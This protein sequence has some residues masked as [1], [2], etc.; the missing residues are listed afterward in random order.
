VDT[1]NDAFDLGGSDV[2]WGFSVGSSLKFGKNDVGRLQATYGEGIE[3][4]LN[5]APIDVGI[6]RTDFSNPR[7]P[8][9]G[10][11]IPV[12]GMSAFLDHNW[13]K[14]FTSAIGY[15]LVN[16][17]NSD[18]QVPSAFHR[19]QYAVANLLFNPVQNVMV[20]GEFQWGRRENNG[21]G[22]ASNDYRVQFSFRFNFSKGFTF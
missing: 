17:E 11:A 8:I 12:F 6:E 5:D 19:G 7:K 22:F 21:D 10:V 13:S 16:L 1:I 14:R 20:G 3:N 9:K 18:G 4:Y 15:S 2:G